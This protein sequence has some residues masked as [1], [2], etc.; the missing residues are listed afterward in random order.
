MRGAAT[1]AR[2]F[3]GRA[4]KGNPRPA[5]ASGN[6]ARPRT[7]TRRD[8]RDDGEALQEEESGDI[9][10]LYT[11]VK[12]L[13]N[14]HQDKDVDKRINNLLSGFEKI[15]SSIAEMRNK[16]SDSH[17]VGGGRINISQHHARLFVNAAMTMADFILSVGANAK[18]V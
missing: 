17:G 2:G 7:T 13:Y 15:I 11:Q 14:M 18:G 16:G 1:R 12:Q 10:K 9:G 4:D 8:A 6:A 3:R 5:T